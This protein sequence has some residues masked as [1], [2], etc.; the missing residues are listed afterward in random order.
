MSL[1]IQLQ[2]WKCWTTTEKIKAKWK[3]ICRLV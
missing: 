3:R 1:W 2:S